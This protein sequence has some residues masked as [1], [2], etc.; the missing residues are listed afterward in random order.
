MYEI[1][2]RLP[3]PDPLL[4]QGTQTL[5]ARRQ[6]TL[7]RSDSG[8]PDPVICP[9][10]GR[11]APPY[12]DMPAG[13]RPNFHEIHEIRELGA[14]LY[15]QQGFEQEY[16]QGLMGHADVKTTEHYQAGHGDDAVVYMKVKAD[17]KM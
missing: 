4:A 17:L 9:G 7:E 6:A 14:W 15:E 8:L 1:A 12:D 16:I 2:C 13:E 5:P 3:V 11:F 10:S